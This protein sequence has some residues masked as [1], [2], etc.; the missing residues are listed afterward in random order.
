MS[1][2]SR[3]RNRRSCCGFSI[4]LLLLVF[5]PGRGDLA[6]L[7]VAA[8]K[9][10]AE[11]DDDGRRNEHDDKL[12]GNAA[13]DGVDF[14]TLVVAENLLRI[15]PLQALRHLGIGKRL[16][17]AGLELEDGRALKAEAAADMAVPLSEAADVGVHEHGMLCDEKNIVPV[18]PVRFKATDVFRHLGGT[19]PRPKNALAFVDNDDCAVRAFV[20][21]FRVDF[22]P[23]ERQILDAGI[24]DW[25]VFT[26]G[27]FLDESDCV[28]GFACTGQ[29]SRE[30]D[31]LEF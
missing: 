18:V 11:A 14:G 25:P 9:E 13:L 5:D 22:G 4:F 30:A 26:F 21:F 2:R 23:V 15:L 16:I 1:R 12:H 17:L 19:S 3:R 24:E 29:A 8:D 10:P 7:I 31:H 20:P 28:E 27:Q 6:V